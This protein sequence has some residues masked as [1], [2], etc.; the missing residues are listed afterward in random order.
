MENSPLEFYETRN[1]NQ[2]MNATY[3][4]IRD[5]FKSL[6][7]SMLLLAGTPAI[8]GSILMTDTISSIGNTESTNVPIGIAG[9]YD[10]WNVIEILAKLLFMLL[11]GVFTVATTYGYVLAYKEKKSNAID[12]GEVWQ[13]VRKIFWI[14]FGTMIGYVITLFVALIILIIP[15]AIV[16]NVLAFMG[17]FLIVIAVIGFYVGLFFVSINLSLIFFIRSH[18]RIGFFASI[19]RLFRLNEGNWWSTFGI[20]GINIYIQLVFSFLLFIPWY[21]IFFLKMMHNTSTELV[22]KPSMVM[23]V[24]SNIS[25]VLY[26]LAG[27]LLYAVP[28]IALAFQYFNLIELKEARGLRSRIETFGEK[29]GPIEDHAEF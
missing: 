28:L 21:V 7:K 10:R 12:V 26:S 11:A 4:F 17:S 16:M 3:G 8:I 20:A 25:L 23:E 6:G 5:H 18:E 29:S 9:L 2:K 27:T 13:Q 19:S 15:L 14:N 22:K 1:F 24:I